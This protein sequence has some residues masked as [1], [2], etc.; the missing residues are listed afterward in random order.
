[1][2]SSSSS[3]LERTRNGANSQHSFDRSHSYKE[4]DLFE[5]DSICASEVVSQPAWGC[6]DNM[7]FPSQRQTLFHHVC[8]GERMKITKEGD[9]NIVGQQNEG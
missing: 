9:Q 3:A 4:F 8:A 6:Y 7:R 5:R 1:M 2:G